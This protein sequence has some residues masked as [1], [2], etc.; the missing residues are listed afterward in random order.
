VTSAPP[1][2]SRRFPRLR[3]PWIPLGKFPTP[4]ERAKGVSRSTGAEVWIKRDDLSAPDYGGNKVR[5][6]E[7][8]LGHAVAR[9]CARV[10]TLGALGSHHA[11]ATTLHARKAGLDVTL[12]LYPQPIDAHVADDLLADH[13]LGARLVR[14]NGPARAFLLAGRELLRPGRAELIPPG[15]SS[16]LGTVGHVEAGLELAEQIHAGELPEPDEV[17]VAFGTGGTAAGLALGFA[18]AGLRSTV[19]AVRVVPA[20]VANAPLLAKLGRGA[21]ALLRRGGARLPRVRSRIELEPRFLGPGYG[22]ATDASRAAVERFMKEDG[23]QL[24]TTYTGKTAAA[25]LARARSGKTMLF[26]DTF[27]SADIAPLVAK[28]DPRTVPVEF[29]ADLRE[30]GRL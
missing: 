25:L 1:R 20:I 9:G 17:Y 12:V 19:I 26:W 23:L 22:V 15:G 5:K 18:L 24:E 14:S 7:L 28:A 11:L 4:V 29:H 2:L 16:S 6:L 8:L 30:A 27:S 13:A 10:I 21:R 3:L